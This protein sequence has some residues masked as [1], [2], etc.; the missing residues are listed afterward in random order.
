MYTARPDAAPEHAPGQCDGT[1]HRNEVRPAVSRL[2]RFLAR[3]YSP[4]SGVWDDRAELSEVDSWTLALWDQLAPEDADADW[5]PLLAARV[6]LT[7]ARLRGQ[8]RAALLAALRRRRWQSFTPS[9]WDRE[10]A[11]LV[12]DGLWR[13]TQLDRGPPAVAVAGGAMTG[14]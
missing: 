14:P 3:A 7:A 10:P 13:R 12:L 6:A 11:P 2:E 9:S 4:R 1:C 5:L 8:L